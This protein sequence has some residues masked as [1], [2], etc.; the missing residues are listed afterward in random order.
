MQADKYTLYMAYCRNHLIMC[1]CV[2]VIDLNPALVLTLYSYTTSIFEL[3]P[4]YSSLFILY[5]L[6]QMGT[7]VAV[8]VVLGYNSVYS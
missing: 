6:V 7:V 8:V 4:I 5:Y 3:Y 2:C 1:M